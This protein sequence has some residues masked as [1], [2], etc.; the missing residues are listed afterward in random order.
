MM[1]TVMK[2]VFG[3]MFGGMIGLSFGGLGLG[4]NNHEQ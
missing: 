4:A 1:M 3:G 2:M